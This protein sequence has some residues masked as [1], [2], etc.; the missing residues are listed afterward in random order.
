M[1]PMEPTALT[2][3]IGLISGLLV[4]GGSVGLGWMGYRAIRRWRRDRA[5]LAYA[6][7]R[8]WPGRIR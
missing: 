4:Y 2:Q 5:Q 1:I 6:R 7:S 8:V 3:V